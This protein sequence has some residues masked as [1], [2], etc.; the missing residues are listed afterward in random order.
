MRSFPAAVVI[1]AALA[2]SGCQADTP[3]PLPAPVVE[4][5]TPVPD[6]IESAPAEKLNLCGGTVAEVAPSTTGLELSVDFPDASAGAKTVEGV[7]VLVNTGDTSF[8]GSS[9]EFPAITLS[10]AGSVMWHSGAAQFDVGTS[11]VLQPGESLEYKAFFTPVFCSDERDLEYPSSERLPALPTGDY[12]V[13]AAIDLTSDD[14][15][16]LVTGPAQTVTL[17]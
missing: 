12:E 15:V 3:V 5:I 2:L 9:R 10:R 1:L 16:T 11:V 14:G 17:R 4:D 13:S 6:S 8:S 7:A